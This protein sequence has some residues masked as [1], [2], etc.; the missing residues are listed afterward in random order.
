MPAAGTG[1]AAVPRTIDQL[2]RMS[3]AKRSHYAAWCK[4]YRGIADQLSG[5]ALSMEAE[6]YTELI[7]KHGRDHDARAVAR[8]AT[9]PLRYL[10]AAVHAAGLL[11]PRAYKAYARAYAHEMGQAPRTKARP[12]F[13]HRS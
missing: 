7:S 2:A 4:G 11:A 9:R 10:A 1:P 3:I 6:L 8:R 5:L 12:T 13:D